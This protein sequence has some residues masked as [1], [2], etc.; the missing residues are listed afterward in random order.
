LVDLV[1]QKM[2]PALGAGG[3]CIFVLRSILGG[4][5]AIAMGRCLQEALPERLRPMHE[6]QLDFQLP[7]G[8]KPE[9]M[10]PNRKR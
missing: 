7:Y 5:L 9:H 8:A 6:P 10:E 2:P 1:L 3:N 4:L